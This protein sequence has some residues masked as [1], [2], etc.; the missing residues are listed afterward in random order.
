M[1]ILKKQL[2]LLDPNVTIA[3]SDGGSYAN[4]FDAHPPFQIDGNFGATAAIAEML[5]Q[6]H[7]GFVHVLPALPSEWKESGSVKGLRA[8]GGFVISE[9]TWQDGAIQ[10]LTIRS[11]IGGNLRLRTATELKN[12]DGTALTAATG[13]NSNPLMQPYNMPAPIVKDMSKIP[14]TTLPTTWLYD[15]PT[16]AG[17]EIKL[18][19]ASATGIQQVSDA[20]PEAEKAEGPLY[21]I[22]GQRVSNSFHGIV[23]TKGAKYLKR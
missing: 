10:S 11:T 8:R 13:D 15:I 4:M 2:V 20:K 9:M 5:V 6:S 19:N 23:V 17:Q 3:A 16:T 1:K 18:I 7:A 22:G 12:A 14:E 21:N